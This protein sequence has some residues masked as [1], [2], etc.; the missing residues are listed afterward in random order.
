MQSDKL[1][2]LKDLAKKSAVAGGRNGEDSF[3]CLLHR[4]PW[5][6]AHEISALTP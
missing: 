5:S 2:A 4:L 6:F 3:A 1:Q